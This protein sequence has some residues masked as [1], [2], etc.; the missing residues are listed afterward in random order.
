MYEKIL[1]V[2]CEV[3]KYFSSIF[4]RGLIFYLT[5]YFIREAKVILGRLDPCQKNEL[6]LENLI[7]LS[8]NIFIDVAEKYRDIIDNMWNGCQLR[9]FW[10]TY[11]R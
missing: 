10:K 9:D 2:F 5:K 8:G 1:S 4:N 6:S 11:Q 7:S 3:N